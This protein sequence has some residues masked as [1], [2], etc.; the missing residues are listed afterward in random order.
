MTDEKTNNQPSTPEGQVDKGLVGTEDYEKLSN[1]DLEALVKGKPIAPVEPVEPTETTETTETPT[2]TVTEPTTEEVI[3]ENLKGKSAD[4]L[5]KDYVNLRKKFDEQGIEVG[6]LRKYKEE[7]VNLDNQMKQLQ[8][9]VTSRKIVETDIKSMTDEEKQAFYDT[10]SEDPVKALMPY[11]SKAIQ[12]LA[13]KQARRDNE[14]EINRLAEL[15]NA[16]DLVPYDK[17]AVDK[18]L[19]GFTTA[20][21]RNKMFDTH[22]TKAFEEAYKIYRDQ[23]L[24]E[25]LTKREKAF[26]EKAIKEAEELA[27]K[28]S[29]T[30]TEPQGAVSVSGG[31]TDYEH[32]PMADLEKL[33]GKP[34]D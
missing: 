32:M 23:Q 24:P 7:A 31:S 13:V 16:D 8:V 22:G 9:D 12:P 14:A 34:K 2:E 25:A 18:I 33:V 19:A 6:D 20:E 17:K 3:P 29:K 15:H 11:I 10:F 26:R 5:A 21:G 28:K 1:K 30:Y 27:N 4:E